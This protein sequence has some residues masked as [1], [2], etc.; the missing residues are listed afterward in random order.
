MWDRARASAT[1]GLD[2][3]H[4]R[5]LT[6]TAGLS[7]TSTASC[8]NRPGAD[9]H[10]SVAATPMSWT[11]IS[12]TTSSSTFYQINADGPAN[13]L[14]IDV[15]NTAAAPQRPQR[16]QA[17]APS[18]SVTSALHTGIIS[19]DDLADRAASLSHPGFEPPPRNPRRLLQQY[20]KDSTWSLA[21]SANPEP[22]IVTDSESNYTSDG[23]G[24]S[25]SPAPNF[26]L[27]A[28]YSRRRPPGA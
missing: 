10:A 2:R 17:D 9:K 18:A 12:T 21:A 28:M 25:S 11:T 4:R 15:A 5:H 6:G 27:A 23:D 19:T 7:S 16:P 8:N 22:Q 20:S 24:Y 3:M 1:A 13:A 14:G 26:Q